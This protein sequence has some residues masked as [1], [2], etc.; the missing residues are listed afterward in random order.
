MSPAAIFGI[1]A[2]L[3]AAFLARRLLADLRRDD[4]RRRMFARLECLQNQGEAAGLLSEHVGDPR[5]NEILHAGLD[6]GRGQRDH[7]C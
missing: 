1:G 7:A 3:L 5:A 6:T 2:A 4:R